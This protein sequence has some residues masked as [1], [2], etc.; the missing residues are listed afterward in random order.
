[1]V[2]TWL[3]DNARISAARF[4][5]GLGEAGRQAPAFVAALSQRVVQ[6]GGDA[7]QA[8]LLSQGELAKV[9][10][11]LALTQA[12]NDTFRVMSWIFLAAVVMAPFCKPPQLNAAAPPPDAH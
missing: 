8:L 11:R 1:M 9:V 2:N 3:Q 4:G 7:A 12:F 5:E 10:G 6:Q